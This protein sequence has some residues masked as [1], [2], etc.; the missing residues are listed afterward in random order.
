MFICLIGDEYDVHKLIFTDR[1][2]KEG[3]GSAIIMGVYKETD[4]AVGVNTLHGAGGS[5][6]TGCK[7]CYE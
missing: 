6:A 5:S 3:V 1:L 4:V 7:A 2:L